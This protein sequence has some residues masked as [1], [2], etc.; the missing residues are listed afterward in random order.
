MSD[1]FES[2]EKQTV[3]AVL[4]SWN[5]LVPAASNRTDSEFISSL[6]AHCFGRIRK[7]WQDVG[8]TGRTIPFATSTWRVSITLLELWGDFS[9]FASSAVLC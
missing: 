9:A 5:Q 7:M 1:E 3:C 8:G 4:R 2:A 6:S